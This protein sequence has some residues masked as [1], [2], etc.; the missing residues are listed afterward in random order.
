MCQA[1]FREAALDN[2]NT[3][4]KN[5]CKT[6]NEPPQALDIFNTFCGGVIVFSSVGP[7][8]FKNGTPLPTETIFTATTDGGI[9]KETV[10]YS[11]STAQRGAALVWDTLVA[12]MMSLVAANIWHW[13]A[14]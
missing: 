7:G 8:S 4:V 10:Y 3:C 6:D 13:V 11:T 14:V 12:L 2:L 5:A 1:S 9:D